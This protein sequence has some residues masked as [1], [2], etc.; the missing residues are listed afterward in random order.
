[1]YKDEPNQK[2][3]FTKIAQPIAKA[4]STHFI[5]QERLANPTWLEGTLITGQKHQIRA[6]LSYFHH[7]VVNDVKYGVK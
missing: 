3:G 4:V 1:M 6:S 7:P 2:M 5:V